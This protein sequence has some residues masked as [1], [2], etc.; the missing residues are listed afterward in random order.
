MYTTM[1]ASS[2]FK[3]YAAVALAAL[4]MTMLAVTLAAGQAQATTSSTTTIAD[5]GDDNSIPQQ[6]GR[7]PRNATP[8][9]CP[10][11]AGNT[12]SL[13]SV[14]DRGHYALFDV[15]WNP[16]EGELTNSVC[17][18]SITY[19]PAGEDEDFNRIPARTD[20]A[21]SSINIEAEPPTIIHI[22]R[23][24]KINLSDRTSYG[25]RTYGQMYPQVVT[26]DNRENRPN[27]EGTPVPGMGDGI[28]WALPACPPDGSPTSNGLCL[29]FSAALLKQ[30]DW[31][32]SAGNANGAIDYLVHHV[33]QVDIDR[34]DPRYVLVYDVPA[35]GATRAG[36][37]LWDSHDARKS[38][39][40]V[41]PGEYKRPLWF[42]T[43]RGTYEFQVNIKGYPNTSKSD[44]ES[45]DPGV[46]SDVREYIVHVGAEADLSATMTVAPE[47]TSPSS[48]GNVSNVTVT[49]TASNAGP[50]T[51]EKTKVDVA[52]PEGLTYSSHSTATGT[53]ANGVWSI[54]ELAVTNDD[55]TA[56]ND[57]SPTLTITA[58]VDAGTHGK[59]LDVEATISA[60]ETVSI[61][62]GTEDGGKE[63]VTYHVPVPDPTPGNNTDTG[64]TTVTR[65]ANVDPMFVVIRSVAENSSAGT[66]VGDPIA[67]KEPNTGDT[68]TFSLTGEGADKFTASPVSGGVQIAVA[69]GAN[70]DYETKQSY[71][72]ALG[73]SDG[74]DSAGNDNSSIDDTIAVTIEILDVTDSTLSVSVSKEFPSYGDTV[75]WTASISP[76]VPAV[77]T[78]VVYHW[79]VRVNDGTPRNPRWQS[80]SET[81][82]TLTWTEEGPDPVDVMMRVSASYTDGHGNSHSLPEVESVWVLWR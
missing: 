7:T 24:A 59:K 43:D 72:L 23:S 80:N 19:V 50:D 27:A 71:N 73:V 12:N 68:L 45:E 65:E 3:I 11:E 64:T 39:V 40:T 21:A 20:R 46:T 53:Y 58:A 60:T 48:A 81:G 18:P 15:W 14:V 22:P 41:A 67:V 29:S 30:T 75:T 82:P 55:N 51:A 78:N 61:T 16:G 54:G 77:A 35:S 56:T 8:E 70:L 31:L 47:S 33:H 57:D 52:L 17:P 6:Q 44:P 36:D 49:I 10:G 2:R 62:E 34:Q 28:V 66:L 26:A 37:P 9:A 38:T 69:S 42:F 4:L 1:T 79:L 25:N 5:S 63:V 74:K 32:D 13:A 76:P